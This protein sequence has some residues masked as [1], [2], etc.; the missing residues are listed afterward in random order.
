MAQ[1][2]QKMVAGV[3]QREGGSKITRDPD[4]PGGTTKYGIA[5]RSHKDVDIECLSYRQAV[6]IY[7]K[8]Y[9]VS[10]KVEK[11]PATIQEIYFDMVVNVGYSRGVKTLQA[12]ANAKGAELVVDGKLGP[13]TLK[14]AKKVEPNRLRAYRVLYYAQLCTRKP[15]ME[16]YWFGWFRRAIEV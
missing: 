5:H 2:F 4:D 13:M 9:W 16:K 6:D 14:A 11:L 15:K 8:N 10:A 12:A 7:H 1:S 3:I